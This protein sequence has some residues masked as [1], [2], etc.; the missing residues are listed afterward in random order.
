MKDFLKKIQNHYLILILK[1][2]SKATATSH[3]RT[4]SASPPVGGSG[5]E[6][7]RSGYALCAVFLRHIF[8][9]PGNLRF[10]YIGLSNRR[11][12]PERYAKWALTLAGNICIKIKGVLLIW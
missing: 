5:Y 6:K 1:V 8:A 12:Q 3:I 7:P 2:L 10:P 4:V 9:S 11:K